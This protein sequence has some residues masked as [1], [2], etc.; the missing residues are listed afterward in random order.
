MAARAAPA[1]PRQSAPGDKEV[2]VQVL[3]R[4]R[5]GA[6][7][8]RRGAAHTRAGRPSPLTLRA[9]LTRAPPMLHAQAAE[10]GGDQAARAAGHQVQR[11]AARGAPL[12]AVGTRLGCGFEADAP[13]PPRT[14]VA[15]SQN[16]GGKQLDRTY[17]FDRVRAA[18]GRGAAGVRAPP[19]RTLKRRP[20]RRR[21]S[22][23]RLRRRTSTTAPSCPPWKRCA[24]AQPCFAR[25]T[26]SA[27]VYRRCAAS[28]AP[29]SPTA[30]RPP[31][32]RTP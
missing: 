11:N 8:K 3:L 32:R 27:L 25:R 13:A 30:R 23:R 5:C 18:R 4:C 14:Q 24:A 17:T 10:C 6:A 2:N 1:V 16:I 26:D 12:L 19:L 31:A 21:F 9:R 29:S 15:V 22:A 7:R 20:P 28:T